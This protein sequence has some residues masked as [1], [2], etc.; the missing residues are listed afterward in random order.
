[1]EK[2]KMPKYV[3]GQAVIEGVMM[4]GINTVVAVRRT[5]GKIQVK[6]LK[7]NSFGWLEKIPFI[8]GFFVL[9]KAMIIGMEALSYS[10]NVSGEEEITKKDMIISILL[11]FLFAIGGFGVG[12]MLVTKLFNI[13]NEF[14]FSLIEGIVRAFFVILYIWVISLFKDIKRVF[15]YH[16]AEHKT[17]YNYEDGKE[18]NVQNAKQYTTLH[19]RCGTSFLIITVFASIVVFSITGALGFTTI[20]EK[21]LTRIILL[22]VVAGFAYEFQRFTAKIIHTRFG[23]I[24]A[25][26]GLALQNITTS[27]PDEKQLEVAIVS[28]K[29]ALKEEFDGE[30]IVEV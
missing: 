8:R 7:E 20:W 13:Q 9:L 23:R 29:Y 24:L 15:E 12:P 5:D 21:V 26:P 4:K 10:A 6:R 18:L 30:E 1:M 11:A 19:P 22:P 14:W 28:L 16:G 17:V 2:K 25:W 27:E 3:G